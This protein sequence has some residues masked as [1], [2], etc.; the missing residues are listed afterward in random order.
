MNNQLSEARLAANRANAQKS[1]GP[2]TEEGKAASSQNALKHGIYSQT[3]YLDGENDEQFI[4]LRDDYMR[5]FKPAPGLEEQ[6]VYN[7][8]MLEWQIR[9]YRTAENTILHMTVLDPNL[10]GPNFTSNGVFRLGKAIEEYGAKPCASYL[11]RSLNRMTRE[12]GQMLKNFFLIRKQCPPTPAQENET[13]Q[14]VKNEPT[15]TGFEPSPEGPRSWGQNWISLKPK[16]FTAGV[17][18]P[19]LEFA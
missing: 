19:H 11:G 16:V 1:T 8:V 18:P 12:L 15:P 13:Q 5:Q 14:N 9:R 6:L 2:R 17:L 3:F 7:I 4:E 10:G